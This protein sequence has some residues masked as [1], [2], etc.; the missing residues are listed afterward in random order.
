L[1]AKS[2]FLEKQI[3][4]VVDQEK[5]WL[6]FLRRELGTDLAPQVTGAIERAGTLTVFATTPAWSARLKF[7]LTELW[8][9]L[10]SQREGLGRLVVKVRP[11]AR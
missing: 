10:Q 7:R 5:F 1:L 3:T 6:E 2:G 8:P 9:V 11:A 4:Q